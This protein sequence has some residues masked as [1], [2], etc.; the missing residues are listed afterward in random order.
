MKRSAYGKP[1]KTVAPGH[2][3]AIDSR[4]R[5]ATTGGRYYAAFA[6][7]AALCMTWGLPAAGQ[8]LIPMPDADAEETVDAPVDAGE[9]ALRRFEIVTLTAL[10]FAAIHSFL[11]VKG[12]RVASEGAISADVDGSDWN[13]VGLG[14]AALAVGIGFYDYMRMRGKDRNETLLPSP[15]PPR[16]MLDSV[17]RAPRWSTPL[18]ALS[19]HF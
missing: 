10:P 16:N 15:P 9:S 3:V 8:G 18:A 5:G 6:I 17:G 7:L 11:I 4:P 12:V 13:Y 2:A 19:I 1:A 14:A